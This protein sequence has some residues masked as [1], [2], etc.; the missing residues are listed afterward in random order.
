MGSGRAVIL[1]DA[2]GSA[3]FRF[4]AFFPPGLGKCSRFP[5]AHGGLVQ[6]MV[7]PPPRDRPDI[8]ILGPHTK[9][10][11]RVEC[12]NSAKISASKERSAKALQPL[13]P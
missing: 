2:A 5:F 9:G 13:P 12:V 3:H 7:D 6:H 4:M 1:H 10:D 8:K 11:R